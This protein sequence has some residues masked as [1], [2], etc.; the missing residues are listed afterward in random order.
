MYCLRFLVPWDSTIGKNVCIGEFL[1]PVKKKVP[2]F[3]S[4]FS[5]II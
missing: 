4:C 1:M 3:I 2:F 5:Y